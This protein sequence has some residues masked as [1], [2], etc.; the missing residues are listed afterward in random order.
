MYSNSPLMGLFPHLPKSV[1]TPFAPVF[2]LARPLT[3]SSLLDAIM[4]PACEIPVIIIKAV[5]LFSP[6]L[7]GRISSS[8]THI[9]S[10]V[11]SSFLLFSTAP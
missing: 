3:G 4:G 8:F 9:Q 11:F 10:V 6:V 5:P 7:P 1:P 2:A